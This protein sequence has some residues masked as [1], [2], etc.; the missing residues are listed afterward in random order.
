MTGATAAQMLVSALRD[1]GVKYIFANF[2]SDHPAIIEALA[3]DRERGIDWPA[4]IICPHESTA[5]SAAHAY[6]AATGEAQAV[7]VHTDV[8]TANLGGAVHNAQRSRVPV[9]IFAGLTPYTLEGELP[10]TRNTHINHLQ[11]AA[12]Q[13]AIVRQYVKW[14]YDIRTAVN[15]PQLVNRG[16]QLAR[17]APQG[18]VYLTGARE[19]LVESAPVPDVDATRFAPIALLPAPSNLVE[20]LLDDLSAATRPILITSYL[21]RDPASVLKLVALAER[22]GLSVVE[23]NAEHLSFPHGHRL[24][25]GDDPHLVLEGADLIIAVDTDAPYIHSIRRPDPAAKVWILNEDPLEEDIPLWTYPADRVVR[26]NSGVLLDQLLT[27]LPAPVPS[28]GAGADASESERR[29]GAIREPWHS[30]LEADLTAGRLTA[31]SVAHVISTVIDEQTIVVNEAI[32]EAPTVWKHL[33]RSEP[34]TVY[35]NRGSSLGWSGGGALGIKLAHPERMIVSIVGDGTFFFSVPSSTYWVADRY[36]LPVLTV[37]LDNG[38]WNATKRNLIRQHAGAA[39]DSTD[40]YWVNLQQSADFPGI[41][42]AAGGAWG[43]TVTEF[44]ALEAAL[45]EGYAQV[46][47]GRPA[48]VAVRLAPISHQREDSL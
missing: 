24:H 28:F 18:P 25:A 39:A 47:S 21:G 46:A 48:V 29:N 38:G 3:D 42:S 5:L 22:F 9:F 23:V 44:G 8:G 30:A 34:G 14:N 10:G 19:V 27:G 2:G 26:V 16:L 45:K 35:G 6:A 33:P 12:D 20:E 32:S 11:D 40:H 41:A 43:T 31:A 13:H 15:V 17:S 36:G 1:A 37:V 7:F 4:V